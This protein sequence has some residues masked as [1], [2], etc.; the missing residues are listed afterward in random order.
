MEVDADNDR[1]NSRLIG[2]KRYFESKEDEEN[3]KE[4]QEEEELVGRKRTR[5]NNLTYS[6]LLQQQGLGEFETIPP[7][8][9][10]IGQYSEGVCDELTN[11][12]HYCFDRPSSYTRNDAVADCTEYCDADHWTQWLLPY[13]TTRVGDVTLVKW[14]SLQQ[15]TDTETTSAVYVGFSPTLRADVET[16]PEQ[17]A[18]L[19][20]QFTQHTLSPGPVNDF[21]FSSVIKPGVWWY[22]PLVISFWYFSTIV[23]SEAGQSLI[24]EV[25]SALWT[26]LYNVLAQVP[27]TFLY[28]EDNDGNAHSGA[29]ECHIFEHRYYTFDS[30]PELPQFYKDILEAGQRAGR[31]PYVSVTV[32][33]T[34][35]DQTRWIVRQHLQNAISSVVSGLKRIY[36]GN[37][38]RLTASVWNEELIPI[39]PIKSESDEDSFC[40]V[41]PREWSKIADN[42]LV[43][44]IENADYRYNRDSGKIY[45]RE[46]FELSIVI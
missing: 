33:Y 1:L 19:K 36:A 3:K 29:V 7:L 5:A 20:L 6:A 12:T 13:L 32:R 16:T 10:I 26:L 41:A 9:D 22:A 18:G 37:A 35:S 43:P 11:S 8:I 15:Y 46:P 45:S 31:Y 17:S 4:E 2:Y 28:A 27:P 24:Y 34:D 38:V 42:T 25:C 39:E 21:S 40:F 44:S 14:I 30:L 23:S